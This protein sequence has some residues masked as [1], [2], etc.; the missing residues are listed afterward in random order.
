MDIGAV[1]QASSLRL[2]GGRLGEASS[3]WSGEDI[4]GHWNTFLEPAPCLQRVTVQKKE[5]ILM[6]HTAE[7]L[8][9]LTD[10]KDGTQEPRT[11]AACS[12]PGSAVP[13]RPSLPGCSQLGL[14]ILLTLQ[15]VEAGSPSLLPWTPGPPI[16][17]SFRG[18][19]DLLITEPKAERTQG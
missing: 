15:R 10:L 8:R 1:P 12:T 3:T 16:L 9:Q 4:R 14:L 6:C 5:D 17:T 7:H 19:H 2:R 11:V 18:L 13:L